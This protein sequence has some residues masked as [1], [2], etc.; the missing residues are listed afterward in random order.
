M[1]AELVQGIPGT[2]FDWLAFIAGPGFAI[3][4]AIYL[5]TQTVPV[6]TKLTESVSSMQNSVDRLNDSVN[7]LSG[8]TPQQRM[9]DK[10]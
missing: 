6:I 4:V 5:L 10:Q 2:N 1:L 3:A 9:G 8:R 7:Y